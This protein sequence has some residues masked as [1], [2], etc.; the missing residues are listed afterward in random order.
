[1]DHLHWYV[2]IL[3]VCVAGPY[4]LRVP[5]RRRRD[6]QYLVVGIAFVSWL[7][8][9]FTTL[10]SA[11][12]QQAVAPFV[13]AIERSGGRGTEHFLLPIAR[14]TGT[15]WINTWP[16]PD[17][18]DR[19][20]PPLAQIPAAWLGGP[21]PMTWTRSSANGARLPVKVTGAGREPGGCYTPIVLSIT[22]PDDGA[23]DRGAP[24]AVR[25]AVSTNQPVEFVRAIAPD[26]RDA[27]E[28]RPVIAREYQQ[29]EARPA[30][31]R[32][33]EWRALLSALNAARAPLT[34][35]MLAGPSIDAGP[36]IYYFRAVRRVT[37]P[38]DPQIAIEVH[39]WVSRDAGGAWVA[40]DTVRQNRSGDAQGEDR[41]LAIFRVGQRMYWLTMLIGYEW[42]D[43]AIDD[44]AR[45]SVR[46]FVTAGGGGC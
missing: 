29:A 16:V 18:V 37:P 10:R 6:W 40:F 19:P 17:D 11:P 39:G 1:M 12:V 41:P 13:V 33:E 31:E 5:P 34:I 4:L 14:Y 23:G 2:L 35:E 44:V 21:V 45:G 38:R 46:R 8:A 28:I 15:N 25:I 32:A 27:K 3:A 26:H 22:G 36:V 42:V 43:F 24:N 20:V 7:L 30:S 9:G